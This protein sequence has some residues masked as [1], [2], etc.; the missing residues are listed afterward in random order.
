[1]S[2]GMLM[3]INQEYFE[4]ENIVDGEYYIKFVLRNKI[5]GFRWALLSVYGAA[6][7]EHK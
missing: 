5:D 1:M 4:L 6:L 3:C 2:G 7:E